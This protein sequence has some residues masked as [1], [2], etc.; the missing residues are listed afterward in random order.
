[1]EGIFHKYYRKLKQEILWQRC[2]FKLHLFFQYSLKIYFLFIKKYFN[3]Q[4]LI[5]SKYFRA[6]ILIKKGGKYFLVKDIVRKHY[7][8]CGRQA[9]KHSSEGKYSVPL[10][11]GFG[12]VVPILMARE[13]CLGRRFGGTKVT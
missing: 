7:R 4:V 2:K 6:N 8:R 1:M 3:Q 11:G 9:I 10:K 13:D 5:F 12:R